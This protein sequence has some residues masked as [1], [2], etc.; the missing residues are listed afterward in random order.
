MVTASERPEKNK[1]VS[2]VTHPTTI[3][4]FMAAAPFSGLYVSKHLGQEMQKPGY[5]YQGNPAVYGKV[6]AKAENS[7]L[8]L[9]SAVISV[10]R[11]LENRFFL[12]ESGTPSKPCS[13][14]LQQTCL[15]QPN[16]GMIFHIFSPD[17]QELFVREAARRAC[18]PAGRY[19]R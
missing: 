9:R 14:P 15:L 19:C 4:L 2:N 5:L 16:F 13:F 10:T 6:R 3:P 17:C 18:A 11:S 1:T 8:S 7:V 12:G